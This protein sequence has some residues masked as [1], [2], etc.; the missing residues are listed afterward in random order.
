MKGEEEDDISS[1]C[2]PIEEKQDVLDI[3]EQKWTLYESDDVGANLNFTGNNL[4]ADPCGLI[5]S[6]F[7]LDT[8]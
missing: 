8:F 7:F 5:A 1:V 4:D 2:E 6:S 3:D